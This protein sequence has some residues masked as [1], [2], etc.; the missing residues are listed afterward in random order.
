MA[1]AFCLLNS[2]FGKPVQAQTPTMSADDT[3]AYLN[4]TLHKWPT[5]E[6]VDSGCPGYEQVISISEDRRSIMIKQNFGR[7]ALGTCGYVQTFIAPV[8]N[9]HRDGIGT[10]SKQGQHTSFF[11]DCAN[12]VDCFSRR[13]DAHNLSPAPFPAVTNQWFLQM[14]APDQVS[15]QLTK[16]IKQLLDSLLTEAGSPLDGNEAGMNR[17]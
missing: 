15:D 12:R 17:K 2:G 6:F 4:T 5:L 10:W 9:L 8:F 7:S 11:M 13:S 1:F 16:A 3:V 14:T